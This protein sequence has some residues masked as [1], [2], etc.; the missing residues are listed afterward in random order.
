MDEN[1]EYVIDNDTHL[2]GLNVQIEA[3]PDPIVLK[4]Y[5]HAVNEDDVD[6]LRRYSERVEELRLTLIGFENEKIQRQF[7]DEVY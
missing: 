2:E 5:R 3:L 1:E 4:F 6:F 7:A